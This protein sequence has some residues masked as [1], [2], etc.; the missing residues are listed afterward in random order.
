MNGVS[1][2]LESQP[3]W[4]KNFIFIWLSNFLLFTTFYALMATLP[5]FVIE[6]MKGN[7]QQIGLVMTTFLIAAV[8]MRPFGGKWLDQLGRKK[9]LVVA[10]AL[11]LVSS[12]MYLSVQSLVV[13]LAIR[14]LHG[15]SFGIGTTATGTIAADIIPDRRKGEGIGYYALSMNMAMVVGPFLGLTLSSH[16]SFSVIFTI[17]ATFSF[18]SFLFGSFT[19]VPPL[20][21]IKKKKKNSFDWKELIEPSAVPISFVGMFLSFA[22]SGLL[23][24]VPVY[25]QEL[26]FASQA[27]YFFVLFAV[28]MILSR[29]ITGKLYDRLGEH[30][31]VYPSIVLYAIG[32]V[33]LSQSHS[34]F[35]FL[36]AAAIIGLGYGTLFPSFQTIVVTSSAP[37]RRGLATSTFLLFYDTGIAV[38]AFVL[39]MVASSVS[40]HAMYFSSAIIVVISLA[41]YYM[42]YH[43]RKAKAVLYKEQVS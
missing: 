39:G 30:Y 20:A 35:L 38:G 32:L 24:F 25:A 4:T 41:M 16:Y 28:I 10:L 19:A 34:I 36:T 12:I 27:S 23:T 40:Y 43:R 26:G 8:L 1:G 3:L 13:L 22:Y 42:L 9:L 15:I 37:H 6:V 2:V 31:I 33:V 7:E 18:L 5:V 21:P 17:L 29:P 14:M 11:F